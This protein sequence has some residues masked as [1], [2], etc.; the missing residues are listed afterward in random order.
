M[1][2]TLN[3]SLMIVVVCVVMEVRCAAIACIGLL[4]VVVSACLG[5][6]LEGWG[7][8]EERGRIEG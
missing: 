1:A 8:L 5:L 6:I 3:L 4:V 7:P 2:L